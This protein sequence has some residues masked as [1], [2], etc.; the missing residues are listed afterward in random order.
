[1]DKWVRQIS[2]IGVLKIKTGI[3]GYRGFLFVGDC[4]IGIFFICSLI[5]DR[6]ELEIVISSLL[7]ILFIIMTIF[8]EQIVYFL[9]LPTNHLII[10]K[11]KIILQKRKKEIEYIIKD[12]TI[13]F[14]SFFE[15]FQPSLLYL[16]TL[17]KEN[18][19]LITKKQYKRI[20]SFINENN[21]QIT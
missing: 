14:K 4:F 6:Q 10:S 2:K 9:H 3:D 15:D 1:M 7:I 19:V 5:Y 8:T 16:K 17:N 21:I 20:V 18:Y 12:T 11:D 13:V